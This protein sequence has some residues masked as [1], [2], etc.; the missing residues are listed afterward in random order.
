MQRLVESRETLAVG[1]PFSLLALGLVL[2]LRFRVVR[3]VE[4]QPGL[5][6]I[7]VADVLYQA[8]RAQLLHDAGRS[9]HESR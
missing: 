6:K 5:P 8:E 4:S 7:R 1:P 3:E 9:P 2:R